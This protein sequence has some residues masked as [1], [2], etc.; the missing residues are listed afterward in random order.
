MNNLLMKLNSLNS[1]AQTIYLTFKRIKAI[2]INL[3]SLRFAK[4]IRI[5]KTKRNNSKM[6]ILSILHDIFNNLHILVWLK[7]KE[8]L[9]QEKCIKNNREL[10]R[11][12]QHDLM[13]II[14]VM[15]NKKTNL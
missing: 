10:V 7:L 8:S 15:P 4:N 12:D 11:K 9:G 2:K 5:Y 1:R 14:E 6:T 3:K 13:L